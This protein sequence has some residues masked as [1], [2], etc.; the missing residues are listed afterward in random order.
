MGGEGRETD[1][2][3]QSRVQALFAFALA[4]LLFLVMHSW[5]DIT[6]FPHDAADYWQQ[7]LSIGAG[8]ARG[9]L[10]PVLVSPARHL[11]PDDAPYLAFRLLSS[12]AYAAVLTLVV[13]R[14]FV[15]LFGGRITWVRRLVP[16][17]L[18]AS[19]YPG[20]LVY[21][22]SD[23]PAFLM[24]FAAVAAVSA[25]QQGQDG[26][27][28]RL[29][30]AGVLA[31]AACN[32][33]QIYLFA[34]VPLALAIL[35][36]AWHRPWARRLACTAVFLSG[37]ML[38]SLPQMVINKHS[39]DIYSVSP[40]PGKNLFSFQLF[41]GLEVQRYETTTDPDGRRAGVP[42]VDPEGQRLLRESGFKAHEWSLPNYLTIFTNNP[43]DV[44]GVYGRH[45][46]NGL[47]VR[48]GRVYITRRSSTRDGM[49]LYGFVLL[50]L[51]VWVLRAG[52]KPAHGPASPAGAGRPLL[53]LAALLLPVAAI[54]PGAVETR[55]FL[56]VH[57]LAYCVIAFKTD[58][59][60]LLSDL[61]RRYLTIGV[62]FMLALCI[63]AA[64]SQATMAS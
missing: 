47:D 28:L 13:P 18:I 43:F 8:G 38:I 14:G 62:A 10:F 48:D 29:L 7:A 56:P 46:I 5:Y 61:R 15:G 41:T 55:F 45:L 17:L 59:V 22:M 3:D 30:L 34:L 50:A 1:W 33:R 9:Y 64:V 31:G 16:C 40:S 58:P 21:P 2:A 52:M 57:F 32:T 51:S 53:W 6:L 23:L 24:C 54:T 42:F 39:R 11:A 35:V 36:G 37:T 12:M 4:T 19:V 49:S 63:F 25:W 26:G 20:L 60:A 44:L 27:S